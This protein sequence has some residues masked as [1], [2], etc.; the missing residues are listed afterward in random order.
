LFLRVLKVSNIAMVDLSFSS[1]S[2]SSFTCK[3]APSVKLF[4]T[5][6]C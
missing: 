1:S 4:L 2:S 3:E 5:P 6:V